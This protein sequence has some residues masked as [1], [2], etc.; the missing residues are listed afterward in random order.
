MAFFFVNIVGFIVYYTH[1]AA[2]PWYYRDFGNVLITGTKSNAAGLLR[3]DHY[4]NVHLF[5]DLYSKGSNVFAAMPS[6]H[7]AYPLAG[8]YYAFKQPNKIIRIFYLIIMVSIWVSAV[9]LYHH[10]V[11]DVL[12][13]IAVALTGLTL[14]EGVI[15]KTKWYS[16]FFNYYLETISKTNSV[17]IREP[18]LS[19]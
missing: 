16:R 2:P 15:M 10:Y 12:A 4:F 19:E 18:Q 3:F 1:P 11:L 13:G 6:L 5:E 17:N 14:F 7:A 9:Y 8:I